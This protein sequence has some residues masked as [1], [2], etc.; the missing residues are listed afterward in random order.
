MNNNEKQKNTSCHPDYI[1][2]IWSLYKSID[3]R[4]HI[5]KENPSMFFTQIFNTLQQDAEKNEWLNAI[6]SLQR[7]IYKKPWLRVLN[8]SHE[9]SNIIRTFSGHT[10]YVRYCSFSPDGKKIVSAGVL[11]LSLIHI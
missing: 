6:L 11:D 2:G 5:I 9:E 1:N 3:Q 7:F 4:S 10:D 8:Y